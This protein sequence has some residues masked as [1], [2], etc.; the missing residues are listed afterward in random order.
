MEGPG[1]FHCEGLLFAF[2]WRFALN[3]HAVG[4]GF[5]VVAPFL[6]YHAGGLL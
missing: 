5:G 6:A 4:N 3:P 1:V 2:S